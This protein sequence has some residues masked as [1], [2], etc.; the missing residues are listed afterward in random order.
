MFPTMPSQKL[1]ELPELKECSGLKTLRASLFIL[2]DM[3]SFRFNAHSQ[4]IISSLF[5]KDD[6][7]A[8]LRTR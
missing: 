5:L 3:L 1:F 4:I 8:L 6:L 7:F 2:F